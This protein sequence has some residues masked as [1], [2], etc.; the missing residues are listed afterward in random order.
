MNSTTLIFL[1]SAL[2]FISVV[3]ASD[4]F[5]LGGA[6]V[7]PCPSGLSRNQCGI[8]SSNP[9][10]NEGCANDCTA[11]LDS[12]NCAAEEEEYIRNS[13]PSKQLVCIKSVSLST[14][15]TTYV[16]QWTPIVDVW[17][18][19]PSGHTDQN[20]KVNMA[21]NALAGNSPLGGG[22]ALPCDCGADLDPTAGG[23]G[24]GTQADIYGSSTCYEGPFSIGDA[25][26]CLVHPKFSGSQSYWGNNDE[27]VL[28]HVGYRV[29][30]SNAFYTANNKELHKMVDGKFSTNSNAEITGT[31]QNWIYRYTGNNINK[32]DD[33]GSLSKWEPV[34][35]W[36]ILPGAYP[37]S[38][39]APGPGSILDGFMVAVPTDT[40]EY[41][42]WVIQGFKYCLS[43]HGCGDHAYPI[44]ECGPAESLNG[45]VVH[46]TITLGTSI[47]IKYYTYHTMHGSSAT[48]PHTQFV[49]NGRGCEP[50]VSPVLQSGGAYDDPRWG[51]YPSDCEI[52][53][54][55]FSSNNIFTAETGKNADTCEPYVIGASI[56][57]SSCSDQGS[58]ITT[59]SNLGWSITGS[60]TGYIGTSGNGKNA[61][62]QCS[63]FNGPWFS[64]CQSPPTCGTGQQLQG[65]S[66]VP[67]G[68]QSSTCG[69]T[70]TWDSES[71]SC[72]P[73]ANNPTCQP[74]DNCIQ[75]PDGGDRWCDYVPSNP[76][77]PCLQCQDQGPC[78][79][80]HVKSAS[81][82]LH[83]NCLP[84]A[85]CPTT[86]SNAQ[87]AG[88]NANPPTHFWQTSQLTGC[89]CLE[90]GPDAEYSDFISSCKP[91]ACG[92]P[93]DESPEACGYAGDMY[94]DATL[95]PCGCTS[96]REKWGTPPYPDVDGNCQPGWERDPDA[97]DCTPCKECGKC[98]AGYKPA[99]S[100]KK[101]T[102]RARK[103][104]SKITPIY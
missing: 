47:T 15:E 62:E 38:T 57:C 66:C 80:G 34:Q 84:C 50:T 3:A 55:V 90:C 53:K 51:S 37:P 35:R 77:E 56:P 25:N 44:A 4:P 70:S 103:K 19:F 5:G 52:M 68:D 98:L 42:A 73:C 99:S 14:G 23:G 59:F 89:N 92:N 11:C 2:L 91:E 102:F 20:Q 17:Q 39:F 26:D 63:F 54:S 95:K 100:G 94:Y 88:A 13:Q 46:P 65:C 64:C 61:D 31:P 36:D 83:P 87:C 82:N 104:T 71:C 27:F 28:V 81:S 76:C 16:A 32:A 60:T 10:S 101:R 7:D 97:P 58:G 49:A 6:T 21:E 45:Q 8:C 40:N 22:P 33:W 18:Y 78:E 24:D 43:P 9:Q 12:G 1:L 29:L 41:W 79:F 96:C 93:L 72:V 48:I 69:S 86:P 75:L 67:C 30:K 74:L 85:A